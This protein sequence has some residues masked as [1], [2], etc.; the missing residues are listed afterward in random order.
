M[1]RYVKPVR[2]SAARG[3]VAQVYREIKHEFGTLGEPLTLH[4]P[5]PDLLVG[6]WSAFRECLL[7]GQAPRELKEAVAVTVSRLNRCPYCIDAHSIMLHAAAAH[8]TA[9]AIQS[10]RDNEIEDERMRSIVA[11][12]A[13]TRTP[14]HPILLSHPF[15][16]QDAPELIGTAVWV[17]YINRM[18]HVFLNK[19]LVPISS[20]LFGIREAAERAGGWYFA[21]FVRRARQRAGPGIEIPGRGLPE[22]L[23]WSAA[24]HPIARAFGIFAAATDAAG[25]ATLPAE[26]R[27]CVLE[28]LAKWDGA[29]PGLDRS[30]LELPVRTLSSEHKP[31][32][33]LALLGAFAPYQ[34]DGDVIREF[35][36]RQ[37]FDQELLGC[38][39]W[40]SFAAARTIGTWLWKDTAG[41]PAK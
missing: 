32:A 10:N 21:R 31:R 3:I 25:A 23:K 40:A 2:S 37:A 19:K 16:S 38:L 26:V 30:W 5:I 33:R 7:S 1:I 29:D 14:G 22:D 8:S 9:G 39:A 35:R 36:S 34:I 41:N 4:S 18:V 20:N 17:H 13:A 28:R 11:W 27:A 12:A 6:V 24:A 15:D